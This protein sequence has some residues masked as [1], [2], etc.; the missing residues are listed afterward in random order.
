VKINVLLVHVKTTVQKLVTLVADGIISSVRP[1]AV[2]IVKMDITMLD[3]VLIH[4]HLTQSSAIANMNVTVLVLIAKLFAMM[5][6]VAKS[7][8]KKPTLATTT[9]H[10]TQAVKMVSAIVI[11]VSKAINFASKLEILLL[12]H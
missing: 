10:Q 7:L 8:T 9:V 1:A 6:A 11:K 2:V 5:I 12:V 3:I 4:H